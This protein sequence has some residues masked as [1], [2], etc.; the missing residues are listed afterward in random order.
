[1]AYGRS[2]AELVRERRS[3]RSYLKLPVEREKMDSLRGF[4][5]DLPSPPFGSKIRFGIIE[6]E[7]P[8]KRIPGTYG[9][10]KG[11]QYF[12][13]GAIDR[14]DGSPEDYGYLFE[15]IILKATDLGLATCWVG[16]TF[17]RSSFALK[18]GLHPGELMPAV[19]PLGYPTERRSMVD[20]IARKSAGSDRRRPWESIFFDGDFSR[21]LAQ[22]DEKKY[23]LP[24]EMLRR[25]PSASNKQPWR[26]I[27]NTLG[28]HLFL[29]RTKGYDKIIKSVDLQR[30]DIGIAMCHFELTARESGLAG[31]WE[32]TD[33]PLPSLPELT[34][35]SVSWIPG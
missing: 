4:I 2:V 3:Y 26:V 7:Y 28:Y 30:L 33:V 1:M 18:F 24:L 11:A 23:A 35:Y 9:I 12:L 8:G 10:I 29:Q 19:S 17:R 21:P 5:S 15:S 22:S 16:G 25:G 20:A 31:R 34:G 27:R 6:S 32:K 14:E 13:A